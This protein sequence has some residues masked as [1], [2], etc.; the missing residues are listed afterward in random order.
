MKFVDLSTG[1]PKE[2]EVFNLREVVGKMSVGPVQ[3][4]RVRTLTEWIKEPEISTPTPAFT[5]QEIDYWKPEQ[6]KDWDALW[7]KQIELEAERQWLKL[8]C[9]T[10]SKAYLIDELLDQARDLE[11][12]NSRCYNKNRGNSMSDGRRRVVAFE[13]VEA[14]VRMLLGD[15]GIPTDKSRE[16][17]EHI[18]KAKAHV[19]MQ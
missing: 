11:S 13:G 18:R 8:K 16:L 5:F 3:Y 2:V 17:A 4:S 1:E 19:N 6:V 9:E 10:F 12:R 15:T 7:E 14:F